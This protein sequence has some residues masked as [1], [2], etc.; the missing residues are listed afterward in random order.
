MA[1]NNKISRLADDIGEMLP[2]LV[3]LVLS[4]NEV[5]RLMDLQPLKKCGSLKRI[6]FID[7]PVAS[8]EHYRSY[9]LHLVPGL[10]YIDF[11]KVSVEERERSVCFWASN[12]GQQVLAKIRSG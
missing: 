6:S 11:Q 2:N 4:T 9:L 7:N 8:V 10:K 3:S 12:D 5:R 1:S